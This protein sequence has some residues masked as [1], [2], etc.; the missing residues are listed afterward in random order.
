MTNK[1]FKALTRYPNGDIEDI[2]MNCVSL[3]ASQ[4]DM[5][6]GDD[7]SRYDEDQEELRYL[8]AEFE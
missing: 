1:E 5:L 8:M 7:Q 6:T 4:I 3:T 2:Q